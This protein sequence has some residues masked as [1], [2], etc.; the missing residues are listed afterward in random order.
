MAPK[1]TRPKALNYRVVGQCW[2]PSQASC[3]SEY[4]RR[5][6]GNVADDL[7]QPAS[8]TDRQSCEGVSKATDNLCLDWGWRHF[9]HSQ[10]MQIVTLCC[11]RLNDI[12]LLRVCSYVFECTRI[13]RWPLCIN[14]NF[15]TVFRTIMMLITKVRIWHLN[16][17]AKFRVKTSSRCWENYRKYNG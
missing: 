2:R 7:G 5:T 11:S 13:D 6:Q 3:K 4:D 1:F 10:W 12:I 16:K 17:C 14:D 9:E 8:G 15:K